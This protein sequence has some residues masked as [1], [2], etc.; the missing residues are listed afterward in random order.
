[1]TKVCILAA[2][3]GTRNSLAKF[4]HKALLPIQGKPIISLII[5]CYPKN[6]HF[7]IAIGHNGHL[8]QDYL[9]ITR[10]N[11]KITFV[12]IKNLKSK[13]SGPGESLLQ[14]KIFK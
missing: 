4:S 11:S 12:K 10:P 3:A 7:I 14:C 5:E 6:T 8:I 9:K 1:M 2:G 13:N